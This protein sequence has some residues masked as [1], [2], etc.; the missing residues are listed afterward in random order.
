MCANMFRCD[1]SMSVYVG[2][3]TCDTSAG[4]CADVCTSVSV[5]VGMCTYNTGVGVSGC[6]CM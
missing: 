4:M 5:D 3:C 6:I 2:V 1:T